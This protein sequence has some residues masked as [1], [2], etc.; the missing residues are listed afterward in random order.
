MSYCVNCGVELA[1]SEK[2]CPLC[3]VEVQNPLH[4]WQEPSARPYPRQ[5]E[6]V[7]H[8]VDVRFGAALASILLLIPVLISLLC[9]LIANQRISWSL[10]V[11]GGA[12]LA[13]VFVLLPFLLKKKRVMLLLSLD[14]LAT[15]LFLLAISLLS[16]AEGEWFLP[17]ALPLTLACSIATLTTAYLLHHRVFSGVLRNACVVL[18]ALSVLALLINLII[19]LYLD[20]RILFTWSWYVCIPCVILGVACILLARHKKLKEDIRKRLFL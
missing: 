6:R 4:P 16:G 20:E 12:L 10:Y 19:Q 18:F 9:N 2:K 7:M 1:P 17:L 11:M 14:V 8:G 15:L 3:N 5:L 13:F